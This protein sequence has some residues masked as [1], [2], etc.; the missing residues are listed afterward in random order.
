MRIK[1]L[2]N[3]ALVGFLALPLIS[4]QVR[5]QG[6]DQDYIEIYK[7]IKEADQYRDTGLAEQAATAYERALSLGGLS[8]ASAQ[9][10]TARL[11]ALQE[12]R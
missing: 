6:A 2:L 3:W 4:N 12:Q 8:S 1:V 5:S 10:A 11:Q 7:L 9:Y